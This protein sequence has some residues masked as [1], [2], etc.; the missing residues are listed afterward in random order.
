MDDAPLSGLMKMWDDGSREEAREAEW[1]IL[2]LIRQLGGNTAKYTSERARLC[3][4]S[5]ARA[6]RPLVYQP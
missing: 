5:S 3:R 1:E 4:P 6:T 2:S